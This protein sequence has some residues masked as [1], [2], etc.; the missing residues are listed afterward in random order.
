MMKNLENNTVSLETVKQALSEVLESRETVVQVHFAGD[1]AQLARILQPEID[2][3]YS[4]KGDS[5][6]KGTVL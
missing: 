3:E 5:L 1:L 4:R 6:S 2:V